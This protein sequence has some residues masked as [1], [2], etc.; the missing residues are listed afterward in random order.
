MV[1]HFASAAPGKVTDDKRVYD[2]PELKVP[3]GQLEELLTMGYYGL[4][5]MTMKAF[6]GFCWEACNL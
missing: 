2:V 3:E 5:G 6:M 4:L 1:Q